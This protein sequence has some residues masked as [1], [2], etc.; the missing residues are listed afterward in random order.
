METVI[1]NS[2][3]D[4][5]LSAAQVRERIEAGQVNDIPVRTSRTVTQIIVGNAF[6]RINLIYGILFLI[7]AS[8]GYLADGIFAILIV[9]NT[10]IGMVQEVRAKRMLDKLAVLGE[11]RP[12]VRRDGAPVDV[13]RN[14]VVLDD[15]VEFRQ[16]DQV[17][18]DGVVLGGTGLEVDE[19]LLTGESDPVVK[20]PGDEVRSGSFVV[21]GSGTY[22]ATKVGKDAYAARLAEEAGRFT[23]TKSG[24]RRDIDRVL[25]F[26]VYLLVPVGALTIFNQLFV[27]HAPLSE[28]LRGMVAAL[29][30][31]V[32][33]GLVLVTSMAFAVGVVRLGKR[34]CLVQELP[35]VEG[36]A[37]VDVVCTDKTGTLTEEGMQ[38]AEVVVLDE[39][40]P[41]ADALAALARV[42]SSPN[43]SA[44]AIV[45]A[46]PADPGWVAD[47]SV[48]FSSARRWSGASFGHN[49][50]WVL[51]APDV[52]LPAGSAESE[53]AHR[54]GSTGSRV[55]LLARAEL[56]GDTVG[57]VRPVALVVLDHR[58]RPDAKETVDYFAAQNVDV[59]VVS[60]DNAATV[61][62]VAATLDIPTARTPQDAQNLPGTLEEATERYGVFG[63]VTPERKREMVQ[64]IQSRG[65]TVAMTGDGV[66][67]VLALKDADIGI[68]MGSGSPAARSVSQFV[69]LDN[70]FSALPHVVAEGRRVI[71]NIERLTTL[72]VVRT[73][74]SVV[75]ALA[76]GI[77]QLQYPFL[78]RH[79]TLIAVFT[80]AI[81]SFVLS[82]TPNDERV[83]PG[84]VKRALWTSTPAGV[85]IGLAAFGSYVAV[86]DVATPEQAGT[87]ALI[88]LMLMA[89]WTLTTIARPFRWWK[90]LLIVGMALS[91]LLIF[92]IPG[93]RDFFELDPSRLGHTT[94]GLGI[95]AAGIAAMELVRFC[96][97]RW[98]K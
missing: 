19:S 4:R 34:R 49:G 16:G 37:R 41:A 24:L 45:D 42:G 70:K 56:A 29:Q 91:T 93:P 96:Q 98:A 10:A 64:A 84:F 14:E 48:A 25:T 95:G 21:A 71:G 82:L 28:A 53:Q 55:L 35:A 65:H 76:I 47:H 27:V 69:L 51:G 72:F 8:T 40:A 44:L 9:A 79:V 83:R 67:D 2:A 94:L 43:A 39:G 33:E 63:R 7:V 20:Q 36:L 6:T 59:K 57:D 80:L 17:V 87:T 88:T 68:A 66:N 3:P 1:E 18:V 86:K 11:V 26:I 97:R 50:Q 58:I 90:I 22:R 77:A 13:A 85:L 78:P 62:A 31:M 61:G 54:I 74:Y 46:Y 12:V 15:V 38:L 5:G 30:P 73:V 89:L 32:P 81:P 75:L 23:L 60:G 52:L 92:L